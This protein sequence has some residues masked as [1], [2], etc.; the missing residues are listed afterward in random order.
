[1]LIVCAVVA[2]GDLHTGCDLFATAPFARATAVIAAP[3]RR[4]GGV[5]PDDLD[6]A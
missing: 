6:A 4:V 2:A 3:I 5:A 1:M